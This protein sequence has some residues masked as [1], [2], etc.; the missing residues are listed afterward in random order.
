[1]L[2]AAYAHDAGHQGLTN[3]YYKNSKHKLALNA[4]SPLEEMHVGNLRRLLR[5]F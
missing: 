4:N 3:A 1:M 2:I 5:E